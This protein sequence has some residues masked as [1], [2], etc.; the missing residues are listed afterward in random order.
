[1]RVYLRELGSTQPH[2]G[3]VKFVCVVVD[4]AFVEL[5]APAPAFEE[6]LRFNGGDRL[7]LAYRGEMEPLAVVR[8]LPAVSERGGDQ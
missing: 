5:D 7:V 4:A 1:M 8:Q 2:V 6:R 3:V